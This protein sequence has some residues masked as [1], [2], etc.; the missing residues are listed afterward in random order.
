MWIGAA[1]PAAAMDLRAGPSA[2]VGPREVVDDDVY[3]AGSVVRVQGR[4]RGDVLAAGGDVEVH[5]QSGG[6]VMA[7]G[8][9]VEVGG[10]VGASVRVAGG[11]VVVR[12]HVGGDVLAAGGTVEL[13]EGV[14]VARDVAL[15]AGTLTLAG[16]VG[17]NAWLGGGRIVLAGTVSGNVVARGGEIVVRP[18]A[19]IRGNLTYSS[20]RPIQIAPQARVGGTV[21]REPYPARPMPTSRTFR[22][23]RIAFAVADFLWMLVLALVLV[24]LVPGSVQTTADTARMRPWASLGWGA[25]LLVGLPVLSVVLFILIVGI[26]LSL[27]LLVVNLLALFVSHAAVGLALGQLVAPGLRSRYGEVALGVALVA[28]ATNL[29]YVGWLLRLL[30]IAVGFGAVA[31]TVWRRRMPPPAPAPAPAAAA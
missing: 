1:A 13:E 22:G 14:V 4:V 11:T 3:I 15:T 20:D 9:A 27:L 30:A 19:V 26:P 23:L 24:A 18:G 10:P 25:L 28:V 8:G 21:T 31:L 12:G 17:R 6:D 7:A 5:G 2:R 16:R 29:P